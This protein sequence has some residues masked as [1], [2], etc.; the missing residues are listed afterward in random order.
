MSVHKIGTAKQQLLQKKN[1]KNPGAHAQKWQPMNFELYDFGGEKLFWGS[2]LHP[3]GVSLAFGILWCVCGEISFTHKMSSR[4]F[5]G[6]SPSFSSLEA[7]VAELVLPENSSGPRLQTLTAKC[8]YLANVA[9]FTNCLFMV[10]FYFKGI[11][12]S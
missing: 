3:R 6:S 2:C 10:F 12:K 7:F 5:I 1:K 4:L 9:R 8:R 11:N